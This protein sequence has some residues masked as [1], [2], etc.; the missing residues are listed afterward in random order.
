ME[1]EASG[2]WW[3]DQSRWIDQEAGLK[4]YA[5]TPLMDRLFRLIVGATYAA[6]R[7]DTLNTP[8][9]LGG[10]NGLRGYEIGEF[11]GTT[12]LVGHLEVRTAPVPAIFSQRLGVVAFYDFGH[13]AASFD[14]LLL[15]NDV[16]LGVRWLI[17]QFNSTVLR[18]DWGVP[19]QDG[20]VTKAGMPG[21]FS[22]GLQ[23]VF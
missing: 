9:V 21:R 17:P 16:G 10:A 5:A 14:D 13:A 20:P 11:L 12:A 4:L 2:R 7:A 23:Q 1:A 8:L 6:K 3:Y 18:F 15:H 19:L 22:A